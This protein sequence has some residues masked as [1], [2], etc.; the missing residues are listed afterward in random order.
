MTWASEQPRR[1]DRVVHCGHLCPEYECGHLCGRGFRFHWWDN[2][3][4]TIKFTRGKDGP[5]I[6]A[7]WVVICHSCLMRHG[8][9]GVENVPLSGDRRWSTSRRR[10]IARLETGGRHGS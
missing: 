8:A 5:L 3:T 6:E 4:G 7:R 10:V 9:D 1:G 2:A